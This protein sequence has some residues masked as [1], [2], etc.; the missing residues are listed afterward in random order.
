[1]PAYLGDVLTRA[2]SVAAADRFTDLED[3]LGAL[4]RDPGAL[5]LRRALIAVGVL[6]ALV[7]LAAAGLQ[8]VQFADYMDRA[9][10]V[11]S[12]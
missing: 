9:T 12:P 8:L 10:T 2:T 1:V 6:L 5:R 11:V 4:D 3:L 7:L